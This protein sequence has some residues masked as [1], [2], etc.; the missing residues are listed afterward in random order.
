MIV[1]EQIN[2]L[3]INIKTFD[4]CYVYC[5]LLFREF[6]ILTICKIDNLKIC[7]TCRYSYFEDKIGDIL[8][9]GSFVN[10]F[11]RRKWLNKNILKKI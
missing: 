5:D 3:Y 4:D 7:E 6:V 9:I 8:L 10:S 2:S 1:I 11:N